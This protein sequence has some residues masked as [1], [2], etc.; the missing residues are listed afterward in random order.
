[1]DRH[2]PETTL[3]HRTGSSRKF[4]GLFKILC[5]Y[6]LA[7]P[8]CRILISQAGIEPTPSALKVQSLNHWTTREV[9]GRIHFLRTSSHLCGLSLMVQVVKNLPTVQETW[10]QSLGQEDSLEEEMAAHSHILAWRILWRE[11]PDRLQSTGS[12]RVRH[13]WATNTN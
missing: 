10:L 6:S 8:T 2:C 3:Q 7:T 12:Q 13:N 4:F 5:M 11:Q 1:M 9:P